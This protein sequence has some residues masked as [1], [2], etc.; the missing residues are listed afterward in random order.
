MADPN[1]L[2]NVDP[3]DLE[4]AALSKRLA[5]NPKTRTEYL[6][7]L[8]KENPDQVIPELEVEDRIAAFAK[9]HIERVEKMSLELLKRDT[10]DK[11]EAKRR[12]LRD[13]GYTQQDI[14][15][16]EKLMVEKQIPAHD[17]AAEHFKMSKQLATPTPSALSRTGVNTLP[18][19][20]KLVKEAGG[21]RNWS[22][23]EAHKAVDDI[24]AGR[25]KFH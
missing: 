14:D 25:V 5:T 19:D 15:A 16:I 24:K 1:S 6:R 9:P 12:K 13:E 10:Q 20:K 7:L 3:V 21:I 11:I 2:E 22:R 8:K 18:I 23:I 4:L 17:T